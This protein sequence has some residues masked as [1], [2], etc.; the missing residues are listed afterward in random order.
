MK[1]DVIEFGRGPVNAIPWGRYD[2][3][4]SAQAIANDELL[5]CR[6]KF[7][8]GTLHHIGDSW[9]ITIGTDINSALWNS[10]T[11]VPIP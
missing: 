2:A 10:I 11:I 4:R 1:Y 8:S 7:G 5:V 9:I 3:T 6:R